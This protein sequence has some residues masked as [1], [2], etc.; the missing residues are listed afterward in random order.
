MKYTLAF[1]I[2]TL[3]KL[4]SLGNGKEFRIDFSPSLIGYIPE[5]HMKFYV[6][7]FKINCRILYFVVIIR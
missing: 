7:I 6:Y 5:G 3:Q 2:L 1:Q 4:W